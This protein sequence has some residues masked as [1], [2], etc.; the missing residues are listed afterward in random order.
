VATATLIRKIAESQEAAVAPL[1]KAPT[2]VPV[3][4]FP[5]VK[6]DIMLGCQT[7]GS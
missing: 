4:F 1:S 5:Y 3:L 6:Q 2:F 7:S